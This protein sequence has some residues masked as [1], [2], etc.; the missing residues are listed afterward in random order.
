METICPSGICLTKI[1][2]ALEKSFTKYALR[3][4]K[5]RCCIATGRRVLK[6][7]VGLR[8]NR[9]KTVHK[10]EVLISLHICA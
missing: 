2:I 1:A 7:T 9:A 10:C 4:K 3:E 5:I 8:G 6:K